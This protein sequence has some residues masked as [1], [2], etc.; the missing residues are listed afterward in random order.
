VDA[1]FA[2]VNAVPFRAGG[3]ARLLPRQAS[4]GSKALQTGERLSGIGMN[5]EGVAVLAATLF[6]RD[7]AVLRAHDSA[8]LGVHGLIACA[9]GCDE[10]PSDLVMSETFKLSARK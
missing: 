3:R 5:W 4:L 2:L 7:S 8:W 9:A 1:A 6:A 10:G